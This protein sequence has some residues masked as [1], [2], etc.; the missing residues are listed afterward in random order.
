MNDDEL[1]DLVNDDDQVIGTQWRSEAHANNRHH[2]RVINA[3][4]V[5]DEGKLWIPRRTAHKRLFPNGLDVSVGG[6]VE[7]GE[8]YAATFRRETREE[9][10]VDIDTVPW[11]D[12]GTLRPTT[13]GVNAF[14][15]V[16]EIR[17]N[18]VPN[19]NPDDFSEFFWLTPHELLDKLAAGDT[20]K[21]DLPI[22]VQ[23]F[24]G[25]TKVF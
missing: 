16:Y 2:F 19:Y 20:C 23:R 13:D 17:M 10:G 15:H 4:V 1:L 25:N 11:R 6:H 12:L 5:N 22:L 24:Y 9:L 14:M 21:G 3:F 8:G 7:S 18:E